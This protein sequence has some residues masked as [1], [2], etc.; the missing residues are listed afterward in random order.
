MSPPL[1]PHFDAAVEAAGLTRFASLLSGAARPA[2][3][4]RAAAP[5]P[6]APPPTG[7]S[8]FG[9]R[10]DLPPGFDWPVNTNADGGGRPLDFLLQVHLAGA[11]PHAPPGELAAAGLL[12]FFYDACD[13]PWGHRPD[14]LGGYRVVHHLSAAGFVPTPRPPDVGELRPSER[15]EPLA[16][17]PI[18]FR[19]RMT[20][21]DPYSRP[22]RRLRDALEA[23]GASGKERDALHDLLAELNAP[24]GPRVR[25][26]DRVPD[27]HLLGHSANVQFGMEQSAAETMAGL[28]GAGEPWP[29]LDPGDPRFAPSGP[30][31]WALLLQLDSDPYVGRW[32]D[33]GRLFWWVR[34]ADAVAGRFDRVWLTLQCH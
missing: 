8:K 25:G 10:P 5:P 28:D 27:H 15:F 20:F 23:G 6:G 26:G 9:G 7:V 32:G 18:T 34:R 4:L 14:E 3:D 16:E 17:R 11:A 31:D 13:Q 22:G 33:D 30:D 29:G 24:P 12:T 2:V 1:P 19:P 21:P